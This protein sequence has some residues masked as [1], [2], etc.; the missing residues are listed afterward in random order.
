MM[1]KALN[2]THEMAINHLHELAEELIPTGIFTDSYLHAPGKWAKKISISRYF[3][4]N[5]LEDCN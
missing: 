1:N 3:H 4:I 5:S 2:C